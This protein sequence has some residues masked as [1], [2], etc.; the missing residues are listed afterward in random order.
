MP[1]STDTATSCSTW[2]LAMT[3]VAKSRQVTPS[4]YHWTQWIFLQL[5]GHYYDTHLKQAVPM[6]TL[7]EFLGHNGTEGLQAS[8]S[9]DIQ[10][11]AGE[12]HALSTKEKDDVLMNYRLAYRKGQL[13]QLVRGPGGQY[14]QMTK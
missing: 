11:T 12:W 7:V 8:C 14:W 9:D 4:F 3:G 6:S 2:D 1:T 10:L 5:Y 13:C